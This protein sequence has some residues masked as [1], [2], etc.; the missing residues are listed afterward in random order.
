MR[1]LTTLALSL[2]PAALAVGLMLGHADAA[3]SQEVTV[4][5][6]DYPVC[7][8]EDCS[9]QPGQVGVWYDPDTGEPW[10]SIGDRSIPVDPASTVLA[11]IPGDW[12]RSWQTVPGTNPLDVFAPTR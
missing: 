1:T 12:A 4:D 6:R 3:P 7:E 9:D 8:M 11:R 2:T 5:D 10:L